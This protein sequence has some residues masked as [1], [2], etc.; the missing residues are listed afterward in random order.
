MPVFSDANH[1]SSD[2]ETSSEDSFQRS[3]KSSGHKTDQSGTFLVSDT[4]ALPASSTTTDLPIINEDFLEIEPPKLVL[5]IASS[6]TDTADVSDNL[7]RSA[8]K[9]TANT[10]YTIDYISPTISPKTSPIISPKRAHSSS[11]TSNSPVLKP[12]TPVKKTHKKGKCAPLNSPN[13]RQVTTKK[14]IGFTNI[15]TLC[16]PWPRYGIRNTVY[17]GKIYSVTRTCPLDTGLFV[18]YYAYKA[19][20]V[21]FRQLFERSGLEIY[22]TLRRTFQLVESDDWTIARLYWLQTFNLLEENGNVRVQ[23]IENTL[24]EIVFRFI[25]PMQQHTVKSKCS[26]DACAKHIRSTTNYDLALV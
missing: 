13:L 7:R 8:R 3:N 10:K 15:G 23:D 21:E 25:Q 9:R 18:L 5:A 17:A 2:N 24:T 16:L 20:T 22:T 4:I 1:S 19:G 14:R 12:S 26:C 6:D 11:T